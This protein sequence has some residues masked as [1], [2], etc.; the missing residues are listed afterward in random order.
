MVCWMIF[1]DLVR[2]LTGVSDKEAVEILKNVENEVGH[3]TN[4]IKAV[5]DYEGADLVKRLKKRQK[6][7]EKEEQSMAYV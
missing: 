5:I 1:K 3:D 4:L 2:K 7:R 6:A